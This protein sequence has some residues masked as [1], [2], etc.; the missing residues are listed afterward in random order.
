[1]KASGGTDRCMDSE[2]THML[3]MKKTLKM[4]TLPL[5]Q[6][7]PTLKEYLKMVDELKAPCTT[8]AE[9]SLMVASMS[10]DSK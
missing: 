7:I 1:M 8:R 4:K 3:L 2:C 10:R 9:T 6:S 5:L